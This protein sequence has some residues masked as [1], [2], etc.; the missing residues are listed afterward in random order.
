MGRNILSKVL[1]DRNL[2]QM[3]IDPVDMGYLGIKDYK[4][5]TV[6]EVPETGAIR[7]FSTSKMVEEIERLEQL[8]GKE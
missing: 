7:I 3:E 8:K 6:V 5:V 4:D 2:K 1:D